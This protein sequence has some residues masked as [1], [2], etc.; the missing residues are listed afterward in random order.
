MRKLLWLLAVV[1]CT[2][3]AAF[4]G[5][6]SGG[7]LVVH[8]TG[9]AWST[10]DPPRPPVTAPPVS[11]SAVVNQGELDAP[12]VW[13]IY[14]V[15]PQ[16]SAPVMSAVVFGDAIN[17]GSGGVTIDAAGLCNT[18]DL[19][20]TD[21]VLWPNGGGLGVAFTAG[22]RT[23]HIEEIYWFGGSGYTD[24]LGGATPEF[25]AAPWVGH[26]CSFADGS[27][28][29]VEDEIGGYGCWASALLATPPARPSR[30]LAASSAV[31]ALSRCR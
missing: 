5:V 8:N 16:A 22:N 27:F 25:C 15:F 3:S 14:A 10:N 28:P 7:V 26:I 12:F 29:P 20:S 30:V 2:A 18:G 6:N 31:P 23:G 24:G 1:C 11:C 17:P 13:K 19:E 4:A 21:G 9:L